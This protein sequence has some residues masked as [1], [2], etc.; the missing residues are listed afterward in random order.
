MSGEI[1]HN[2]REILHLHVG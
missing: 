1:E 2:E